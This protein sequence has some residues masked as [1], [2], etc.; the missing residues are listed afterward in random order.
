MQFAWQRRLHQQKRQAQAVA[1]TEYNQELYLVD[2]EDLAS[3][4]VPV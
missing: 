2:N 4:V 3:L 1:S